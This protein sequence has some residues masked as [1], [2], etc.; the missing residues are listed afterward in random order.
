M[1]KLIIAIDGPS[2][3]GKTYLCK[4]LANF[5]FG[6]EDAVITAK[7]VETIYEVPLRLRDQNMDG[8]VMDKLK[9]S[10]GP[11]DLTNWAK[12]VDGIYN[13]ERTVRIALVGKY[14]GLKDAYKSIIES[15]VHAGIPNLVGVDLHWVDSE[16][17]EGKEVGDRKLAEVFKDCHG[18]L[19]PGGFGSRGIEGKICTA[20][21]ARE[22]KVPYFG[23][24]L[25]MQVAVVE[26]ARHV[27]GLDKANSSEFDPD[28][29]LL[30]EEGADI[31]FE[32]RRTWSRYWLI[33]P[34][35]GT[36]EFVKRNGEFTV[37]IAL[38]E[39]GEPTLGV[40]DG[41]A[42]GHDERPVAGLRQ[43]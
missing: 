10:A 40:G 7:D 4:Q 26:F 32:Q 39:N 42:S 25:G 12:I 29:P 31:P 41:R 11:I 22:N 3:V 20:R 2:G 34:L 28:T 43:E 37:N 35:D 5:M 19:V 17:L 6:D 27:A 33:D 18:V 21:Y 8:I 38:I 36:R 15:F 24:C 16:S 30:S 14:T 13:A 9:L 23:I 1:K